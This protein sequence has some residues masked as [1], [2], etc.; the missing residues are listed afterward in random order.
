V[1]DFV[2]AKFYCPQA[3]NGGNRRIPIMQKM[4]EFSATVLSILSPYPWQRSVNHKKFS[5]PMSE[6]EEKIVIK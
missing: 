5:K 6:P 4:M 3:L 2:G 1:E